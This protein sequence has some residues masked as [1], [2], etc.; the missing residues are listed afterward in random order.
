M[1]CNE[2]ADAMSDQHVWLDA[3]TYPKFGKSVFGNKKRRL[4]VERIIQPFFRRRVVCFIIDYFPNVLAN[5]HL[6][7]FGTFVDGISENAFLNIQLV[8]H[9]QVL[10]ALPR[11]DKGQLV[12][13]AL[14]TVRARRISWRVYP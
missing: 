5:L 1:R 6:E 4:G 8:T 9:I 11:K 7:E 14:Q 2:L 13:K 12:W 10:C 3:P